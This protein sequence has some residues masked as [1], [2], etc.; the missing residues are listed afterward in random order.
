MHYLDILQT[1]VCN[2][3]NEFEVALRA[4]YG[5]N[6]GRYDAQIT[7]YNEHTHH[8]WY[9]YAQVVAEMVDYNVELRARP[10]ADGPA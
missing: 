8:A 2:A 5:D 10:L 7:D 6:D 3:K 4:Q 1:K 9:R